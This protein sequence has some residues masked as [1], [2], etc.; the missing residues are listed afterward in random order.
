[1]RSEIVMRFYVNQHEGENQWL[2]LNSDHVHGKPSAYTTAIDHALLKVGNTVFKETRSRVRRNKLEYP[3]ELS[4]CD[5]NFFGSAKKMLNLLYI[6]ENSAR[7]SL[8][9]F[10]CILSL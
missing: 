6:Y 1:M 9:T 4:F 2:R 5:Y 8:A 7:F 3:Q 10:I